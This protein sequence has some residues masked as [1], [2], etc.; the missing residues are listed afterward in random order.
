MKNKSEVREMLNI[1][2][3]N[4]KKYPYEQDKV[5]HIRQELVARAGMLQWVLDEENEPIEPKDE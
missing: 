3:R 1:I 4:L 2:A 5:D